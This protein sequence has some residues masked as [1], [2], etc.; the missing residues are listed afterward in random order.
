L[1]RLW[2][3]K[4]IE[5]E[6]MAERMGHLGFNDTDTDL[7]MKG[8]LQ[9]LPPEVLAVLF[10]RKEI[11]LD[12]ATVGL[13]K[14]GFNRERSA[15]L[16]E[17][18]AAIPGPADILHFYAKEA[19]EQDI[20]SKYG[21]DD[22]FPTEGVQYLEAHGLSREWAEKYWYAHWDTPSIQ[23]GFEMLHRGVIGPAELNDLFKTIE[24][25]PYWR[26]K[27]T[28]IAHKLYTRVDAR[29]MAKDN[30]LQPPAVLENYRGLG[31]DEEH[32]QNLTDWTF[33][34]NLSGERELTRSQIERALR[35]GFIEPPDAYQ[36]F[37]DI[38]YSEF[39]AGQFIDYIAFDEEQAQDDERK[40]IV[41]EMYIGGKITR[42]DAQQE[43]NTLGFPAVKVTNLLDRWTLKK[44]A[45]QKLPSKSDL[46]K[47]I[48]AGVLSISGYDH[49]MGLIGYEQ[50][51]IDLFINYLSKTNARVAGYVEEGIYTTFGAEP[52]E[53]E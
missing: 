30:I 14:L 39:L 22:E 47:F 35:D 53:P 17:T 6:D 9:L 25:P 3:L 37:V 10:H 15:Q 49:Y 7:I 41:A 42:D 4:G 24:I 40:D 45:A 29:R 48:K 11:T 19:F 20:I 38:G 5:P 23:Q 28:K 50:D 51:V 16:I 32:A 33:R 21:Y 26:D 43:L 46:D 12:E 31:Y 8:A 2:Y 1:I 13:E 18:W 36:L 44:E 52:Q 34:E 27:L